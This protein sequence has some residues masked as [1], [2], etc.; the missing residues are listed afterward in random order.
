MPS[1]HSAFL[2]AIRANPEDDGPRLVYADWLEERGECDLAEFIRIGLAPE[3]VRGKRGEKAFD[4]MDKR[5]ANLFKKNR[6]KWVRISEP[7]FK[8]F[9]RFRR[10]SAGI[11]YFSGECSPSTF[12]AR[13]GAWFGAI[14]VPFELELRTSGVPSHIDEWSRSR[15]IECITA[16][17]CDCFSDADLS[18]DVVNSYLTCSRHA[19][20]RA[21]EI[22]VI[23]SGDRSQMLAYS[24]QLNNLRHLG[25][26]LTSAALREVIRIPALASL[27]SVEAWLLDSVSFILPTDY[28]EESPRL[29]RLVLNNVDND[30]IAYWIAA[31]SA[32]RSLR[33]LTLV[34]HKD[35]KHRSIGPAGAA[36]LANSPYLS[37]LEELEFGNQLIEEEGLH[38][39]VASTQLPNLRKLTLDHCGIEGRTAPSIAL[40]GNLQVNITQDWR[41]FT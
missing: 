36:A 31:S 35:Q 23:I 15:V 1:A 9:M 34:R 20:L 11:L 2:D 27:R 33:Q 13:A 14:R 8:T 37:N 6:S 30:S 25:V 18:D 28:S 12:L 4:E 3:F 29:R 5:A 32:F 21:W 24:T 16:L 38:A 19:Q 7:L 10:A 40:L 41:F 17:R 39:V 26:A 22:E